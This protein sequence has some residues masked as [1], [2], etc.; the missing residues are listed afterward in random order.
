MFKRFFSLIISLVF[1]HISNA[2]DKSLDYR[3]S[4]DT[5]GEKALLNV[6]IS[7]TGT[8]S[9]FT[10]IKLPDAWA[11]Q[12]Q[13]YKAVKQIQSIT[14]QVRIDS[15]TDSTKKI[16]YHKPG[17]SITLR[18]QLQ[19]DWKGELNYPKNYRAII[20]KNYIHLTGY[21]LF[22]KP[23]WEKEQAVSVHLDWS[24]MPASWTVGNSFH[25]SGKN[26]TGKTTM[27]DLE[28][29][30]YV[31]GDFRLYERKIKNKPV[32]VAIRGRDWKFK[33]TALVNAAEKII[34]TER[35]FWNDFEEPYYFLSMI[36]FQ[37]SGNYNGS[38]LHQSFLMGMATEFTVDEQLYWLLAHEY[39]HRWIGIAILMKG[40]EQENSWFGEGFTDY[41][42]HKLLNKTGIISLEN[43]ISRINGVIADYYLS[44]VRNN[45]IS[46]LG[47]NFW[48]KREY[49]VIPY[50]KGFTY[51][52][53]IDNLIQSK[54]NHTYS[55]DNVLFDLYE[56]VK[57]KK[58]I[59][60]ALFLERIQHYSGYDLKPEHTRYIHNG[61]TIPVPAN[62]LGNYTSYQ[63]ELGAFD[64]GF[65]V[66]TSQK[67]L[68]ITGVQQ[69]SEAWKAGLRDGQKL[70]GWS[71][72][73]DNISVPSEITIL[74]KE[75]ALK[76]IS[77]V[78]LSRNK[79][80]LP[81]FRLKP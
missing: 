47:K 24:A 28:N 77:Y 20:Q 6:E 27:G 64:M 49:Q 75:N 13:L 61:E 39:F 71:V 17:Q 36:P 18:Y 58:E 3:F 25:A 62:I 50:K 26:F 51:A 57:N 30:F 23:V 1:I 21:A 70:K 33:D 45:D 54:S 38:A 31:A 44:P 41:Y 37:G 48:M 16:I 63:K 2:Q 81:Q 74:D 22:I 32:W 5:M 11:S 15:T 65:D 55:L 34:Y 76:K 80:R 53:L 29:S 42:T 8:D 79:I 12:Q 14:P 9:G 73:Y 10:T 19:Q 46:T 43:Y 4:I 35:S 52:L 59:T 69:D 78:P 7:F 56:A 40:D 68:I 60:E 67:S 66:E 72:H